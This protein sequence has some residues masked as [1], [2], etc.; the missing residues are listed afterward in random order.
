MSHLKLSLIIYFY[1][2]HNVSRTDMRLSCPVS[3]WHLLVI[4]STM[5]RALVTVSHYC[6]HALTYDDAH[7]K[8]Q[9]QSYEEQDYQ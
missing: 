3:G 9:G 7:F 8:C 4:S 5:T 1:N 2:L 6:G